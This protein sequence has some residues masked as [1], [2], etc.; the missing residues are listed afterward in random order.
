MTDTPLLDWSPPTPKG[1][2]FELARDGA[3]LCAQAK[4]VLAFCLA[5]DWV[6][7]RQISEAC[8]DPEASA[9]ARLRDLRRVGA[10]RW[11][12]STSPGACMPTGCS[13]MPLGARETALDAYVALG[14]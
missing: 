6:T 1:E 7:L 2:T 9:S 8:G 11:S 3:R 12:G 5:N 4:R 14:R 13:G 10:S